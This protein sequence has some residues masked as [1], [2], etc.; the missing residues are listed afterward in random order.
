[1]QEAIRG[2]EADAMTQT[3][4][5]YSIVQYAF[6]N[7]IHVLIALGI[8]IIGIVIFEYITGRKKEG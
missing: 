6:D 2:P 1:M 5:A 8:G 7:P 4:T 3:T